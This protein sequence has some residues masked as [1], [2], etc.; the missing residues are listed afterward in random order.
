VSEGYE[1]FE[2]MEDTELW[3]QT[4]HGPTESRI[5]AL[6]TLA[7]RASLNETHA[8]AA[9]LQERIAE[10]YLETKQDDFAV[11]SIARAISAWQEVE[12][13]ENIEALRVKAESLSDSV[14]EATPWREFYSAYGWAAYH[15]RAYVVA[16][17]YV[18]KAIACAEESGLSHFR[19]LHLWQK[20]VLIAALGR[21]AEG[22]VF[23]QQALALAREESNLFMVADILADISLVHSKLLDRTASL[24]PAQEAFALLA[25]VPPFVP[26]HFRVKF[27]LGNAYLST[28]STNLAFQTFESIH[29]DLPTYL[30]ARTMIR[31]SEC[32]YDDELWE[33]RAYTVAK[34]SNAW[35]LVDHIDVTRA[36]RAEPSAAIASLKAVIERTSERDDDVTRDEA[37]LVLAR[38]L[39]DA[40]LYADALEQLTILSV[41]N[42]GDDAYKVLT[43]LVLRADAL[44]AVGELVEAR[45]IALALSRLDRRWEVID[46]IA[47]GYWQLATIELAAN[48]PNIEW[49]RL[50]NQSISFLALEGDFE[51]LQER[52]KILSGSVVLDK[53]PYRESLDTIDALLA[54]IANEAGS[55]GW[56]TTP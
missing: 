6:M 26:L 49:E 25:E 56:T 42:F 33:S 15:R 13:W 20:G 48:G 39:C 16:L 45:S 30:K 47:E 34:N 14:F 1:Q 27:A 38:K 21:S 36:M 23:L 41:A 8:E 32:G 50:A 2:D 3:D 52:A 35:D 4:V 18:E 54:D 31:M 29:Q 43:Y 11:V 17:E 7:H 37:R 9:S 28:G 22:L 44:I 40:G 55:P 53:Q 24:E 46:A 12:E 51:L 19:A 10:L 5:H